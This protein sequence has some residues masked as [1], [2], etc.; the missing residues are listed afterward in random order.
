M[1]PITIEKSRNGYFLVRY[2]EF[3]EGQESLVVEL[4]LGAALTLVA[5]VMQDTAKPIKDVMPHLKLE[6]AERQAETK[7]QKRAARRKPK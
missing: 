6:V 7:K 5:A 1:R 2:T 3:N 4:D